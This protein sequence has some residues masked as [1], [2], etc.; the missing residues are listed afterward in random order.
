[1]VYMISSEVRSHKPYAIPIQCVP[2]VGLTEMNGRRLL[3]GII[4]A[5]TPC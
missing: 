1:M 4:T 2:Y 3:Q 5:M